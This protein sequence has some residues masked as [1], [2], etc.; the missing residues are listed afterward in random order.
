[1]QLLL[2]ALPVAGLSWMSTIWTRRLAKKANILD[3]PKDERKIHA[4][5]TPLLG[6]VGI[7][8]TMVLS[9]IILVSLGIIRFQE[10]SQVQLIGFC[11]ALIVLLVIGVLDDKY[12]MR[13]STRFALLTVASLIILFSGT[14]IRGVSGF[15]GEGSLSLVWWQIGWIS[16][17]SD[18]LTVL[19]LI[20]V[21]MAMKLMDGIDG[22]VTGQTAIGGYIIAALAL[23]QTFYQ[24]SVATLAIIIA[25]AFLGFLFVNRHPA[26]QFLGESGSLIAG[27][28][29]GFLSIVSGTKVATALMVLGIPLIDT[30]FVIIGRLRRKA[31]I[32]QGDKTHLH[33][34]LLEAGLS[35]RQ[36]AYLIWSVSALFGL[37]G[38]FFQTRGKMILLGLLI[39]IAITLSYGAGLIARRKK[40]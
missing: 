25:G 26:K 8:I 12:D 35:Q 23:T 5:P 40:Q 37:G 2:L 27:F 39:V 30:I 13:A 16:L 6:G 15:S 29:L 17:P 31:P 21:T 28:S 34:K 7:G 9:V 3:I 24:P 1:M 18:L 38:L 32:W 36:T 22:L 4:A 11:I 14:T 33:H 10:F 19:W 20:S